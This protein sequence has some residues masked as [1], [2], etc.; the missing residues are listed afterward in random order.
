MPII[1]TDNSDGTFTV[2]C[3]AEERIYTPGSAVQRR[4]KTVSIRAPGAGIRIYPNVVKGN[5]GAT[6]SIVWDKF[7]TLHLNSD[8]LSGL[9][10]QLDMHL[11]PIH[12]DD[13]VALNI[14]WAGKDVPD[15]NR[16]FEMLEPFDEKTIVD[17]KVH[18]QTDDDE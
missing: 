3:G 12:G 18:F 7:K 13:P 10:H 17:C 9:N 1:I 4:S 14:T 6:A 8:N 2:K 5:R 11:R 16:I 15:Y